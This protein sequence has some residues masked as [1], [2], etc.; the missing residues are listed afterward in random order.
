MKKTKLYKINKHL[1][2]L[3]KRPSQIDA[4]FENRKI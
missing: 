2:H 3:P 4:P 1:P